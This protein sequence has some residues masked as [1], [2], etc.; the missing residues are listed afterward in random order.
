MIRIPLP[1]QDTA[2]LLAP[3]WGELGLPGQLLLL[4]LLVV[5]M[6]LAVWLYR[7][8]MR[9]DHQVGQPARALDDHRVGVELAALS[10]G[11]CLE[12]LVSS[13]LRERRQALATDW[14]CGR[15]P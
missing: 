4:L 10:A 7:Y 2:L 6:V 8:E 9:L 13:A 11:E 1:E 12:L 5:P 3:R 14:D 15:G